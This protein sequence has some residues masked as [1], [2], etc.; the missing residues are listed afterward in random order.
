MKAI[1]F[2]YISLPH[3]TLKD[4]YNM[5][6]FYHLRVRNDNFIYHFEKE[7]E[8][9]HLKFSRKPDDLIYI[10]YDQLGK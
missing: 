1:C 2:L 6:V 10:T 3:D 5:E 7:K 8:R 9:D 4:K